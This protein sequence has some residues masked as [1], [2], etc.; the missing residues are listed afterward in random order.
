VIDEILVAGTC[1]I[2][3][4]C[5]VRCV[6]LSEDLN[7]LDMRLLSMLDG[8]GTCAYVHKSF[9]IATYTLISSRN[10]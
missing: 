1:D 10:S 5:I 9:A 4:S 3:L 6:F 8:S 7:L 2:I